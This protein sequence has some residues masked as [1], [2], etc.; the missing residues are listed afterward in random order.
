MAT[1][2]KP[3][4]YY[5][6][7][8]APDAD[9]TP[10]KYYTSYHTWLRTVAGKMGIKVTTAPVSALELTQIFRDEINEKIRASIQQA[11]IKAL[12]KRE[13]QMKRDVANFKAD[14]IEQV[15]LIKDAYGTQPNNGASSVN[16]LPSV[17]VDPVFSPVSD[18][19]A[20]G[21]D[22]IPVNADAV[23]AS[24]ILVPGSPDIQEAADSQE[25]AP[26]Q[27]TQQPPS[28]V[29]KILPW[30]IALFIFG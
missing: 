28:L 10:G 16:P 20:P 7:Y 17:P 25:A 21:N 19:L 8:L 15:E 13:R 22:V 9:H 14:V 30:A 2:N 27:S 11:K 24:Q 23:P 6:K 3:Q 18:I 4:S 26:Q 29:A 12:R 1:K 5:E